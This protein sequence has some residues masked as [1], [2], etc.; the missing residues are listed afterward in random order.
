MNQLVGEYGDKMAWG[1][2]HFPLT[3]LH[4]DAFHKAEA[5]E[6]VGELSDNET[7]WKYLDSLFVN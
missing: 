3:Q 6:C 1:F 4:P 5:A 2:R 7:F